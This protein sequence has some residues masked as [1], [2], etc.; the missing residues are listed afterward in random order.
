MWEEL[1]ETDNKVYSDKLVKWKTE[2][3]ETLEVKRGQR[4]GLV[5]FE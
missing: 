3:A 1:Y 2:Q 5:I 4:K